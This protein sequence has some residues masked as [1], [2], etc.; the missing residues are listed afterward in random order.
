MKDLLNFKEFFESSAPDQ[1]SFEVLY[2]SYFTP[3]YRYIFI[4]LRD[5]DIAM[6]LVQSVFLKAFQHRDTLKKDQ[7]LQYLYTIA[8][9]Q[10]IDYLR[11]KHTIHMDDFDQFIEQITDV[12]IQN[13]E[14]AY[15]ANEGA[16]LVAEMLQTLSEAER[17]AITLRYIQDL[18][19]DAMEMIT[20]KSQTAL[21]QLVSRGIQK[22]KDRYH[23][24]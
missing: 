8:R 2:S 5:R 15:N 23:Y 7:A 6:D 13:P 12:S 16:Q 21:R 20:G 4:R 11:K 14:R 3:I 17:D 1:G 18:E 10:I 9:N 22:L 19:Y 24:E